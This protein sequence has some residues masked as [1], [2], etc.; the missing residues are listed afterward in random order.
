MFINPVHTIA[1]EEEWINLPYRVYGN[2]P[3]RPLSPAA[4]IQRVFDPER[5]SFLQ[6]G[7]ACRWLAY[8]DNN[9][10]AGRI[11]AF[12]Q[13]KDSRGRIGFFDSLNSP[14]VANGLFE[15]AVQWLKARGCTAVEA[16][17]NFGEKDRYWGLMTSGFD[18]A[19]LYLDNFNPHYYQQLFL[20][21]G[22]KPVNEIYTYQIFLDSIPWERL[23]NITRRTTQKCGFAYRFFSWKDESRL[24]KDIHAIYTASFKSE[25]RVGYISKDDIQAL[26]HEVKPLLSERHFCLA[27]LAERPI[28]FVA[29][30]NEPVPPSQMINGVAR[31]IKGFAFATLPEI[32]G[33]GVEVGLYHTVMSQI[34]SEGIPYEIF[35][36]GI[37]E[38]TRRMHALINKI[39]GVKCKTHQTFS[40][41]I[42]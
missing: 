36:S 29:F 5:N 39:G 3:N 40:Y 8:D 9:L 11:A 25:T 35:L 12:S 7:T 32:R 21:F 33:K 41:E 20:D 22:F 13:S 27:Y 10:P 26:L 38:T 37:N 30:L 42:N 19:G 18:L 23:D 1:L 15:S 31:R 16:P 4:D 14:G 28:G 2:N 24:T 17:V 6:K 34:R